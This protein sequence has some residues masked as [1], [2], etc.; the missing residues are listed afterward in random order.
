MRVQKAIIGWS[1]RGVLIKK[2]CKYIGQ[3]NCDDNSVEKLFTI[4]NISINEA[5]RTRFPTKICIKPWYGKL[6]AMHVKS[7][8]SNQVHHSWSCWL[9]CRKLA[10]YLLSIGSMAVSVIEIE[11]LYICEKIIG[12]FFSAFLK[13][14]PRWSI[15]RLD[16]GNCWLHCGSNSNSTLSYLHYSFLYIFLFIA[17]LHTFF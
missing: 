16:H 8:L 5:Y 1:Y 4:V 12:R 9:S 10:N 6:C 3:F 11:C 15:T 14:V 13:L 17:A 7:L 2:P